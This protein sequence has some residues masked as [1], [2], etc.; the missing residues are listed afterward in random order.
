MYPY[1]KLE[2]TDLRGVPVS[3][4]DYR[5]QVVLV[6]NWATW[7]PPCRAEMPE[8]ETYFRAHQAEGFVLLGINSGETQ[9][10]VSEF[11]QSYDLTFPMWL[12]PTGKA[13]DVF[14]TNALPSSFVI[15]RKG[16][17]RL[18][19]TG[20]IDAATLEAHVTPLLNE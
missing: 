4:E 14:G 8:L 9:E 20:G 16:I 12:D 6:N 3:L 2:L 5:G 18:A 11:V 10:Q 13:L 17:V 19:W 7:C 1:P 15:D